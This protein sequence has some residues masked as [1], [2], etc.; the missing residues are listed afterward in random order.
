MW[1]KIKLRNSQK[2]YDG[3]LIYLSSIHTN[4]LKHQF[5]TRSDDIKSFTEVFLI[6][7]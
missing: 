4:C 6:P 3:Q 5:L 1:K 7:L 2:H